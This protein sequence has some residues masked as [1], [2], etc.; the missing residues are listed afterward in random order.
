MIDFYL[1]A[2]SCLFLTVI[3]LRCFSLQIPQMTIPGISAKPGLKTT[4][5]RFLE[6]NS[7]ELQFG[8]INVLLDPVMS[9][10]DFGIPFLYRGNKRVINGERELY[11]ICERTDFVLISQGFDD[12]AHRPTL[13]KLAKIAP[14]M[15]Y[16]VA[17]AAKPILEACGIQKSYISNIS[18][19]QSVK[20]KKGTTE[21]EIIAT[22]GAL[23]GPPWQMKENGYIMRPL[24]D[25]SVSFP[26]LYYEPHCM[27]DA[28][29]LSCYQV[30]AVITPIISQE[31]PQYTLV[32]GGQ[33]AV[34]L[35][36]ALK[37]KCIIPMANGELE[38]EGLLASIIRA[39]GSAEEVAKLAKRENIKLLDVQ[40]GKRIPVEV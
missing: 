4:T 36:K 17:P 18:H 5:V 6:S 12:H 28:A 30:D 13:T 19:R 27:Y 8:D 31:L 1:V 11:S 38:Q 7:W 21:L 14:T 25:S 24:A 15:K 16:F 33:K 37:A 2:R 39:Q 10:L 35:A 3:C 23:L 9:Q 32:A 26:S 40:P 34:D 20:Y 22:E 29:E